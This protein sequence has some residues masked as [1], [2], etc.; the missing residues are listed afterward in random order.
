MTLLANALEQRLVF[1][2]G[3]AFFVD[4]T[5]HDRIRLSFSAPTVE[6]IQEGARR[7]AVAL[8][9]PVSSERTTR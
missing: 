7:L 5:G 8:L 9:E 6:R 2:I 3:S 4:G 1:V